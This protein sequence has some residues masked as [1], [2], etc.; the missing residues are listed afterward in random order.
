MSSVEQSHMPWS[1]EMRI[2]F[3]GQL[4]FHVTDTILGSQNPLD[5]LTSI[6]PPYSLHLPNLHPISSFC[7]F[8]SFF[9]NVIE[10]INFCFSHS[11]TTCECIWLEICFI[12]N[13][14]K[15]LLLMLW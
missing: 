14:Y 6:S 5:I 13:A 2:S 1:M 15:H 12:T 7:S 8:C 10:S 9:D 4:F 3:R 11:N